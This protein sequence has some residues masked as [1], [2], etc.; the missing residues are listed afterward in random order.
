VLVG[1]WAAG[2]SGRNAIEGVTAVQ[3]YLLTYAFIVLGSFAVVSVVSG[4]GDGATAIEDY[5]GL[6]FR[7][8]FLAVSF[9]LLLAAQAGVPFTTG[10]L[11]KF[12]VI[13][14]ALA[15]TDDT[16]LAVAL[17]LVAML[18]TAV[19]V[20]FYLRLVLKMFEAPE[21]V[22]EEHLSEAGTV[23]VLTRERTALAVPVGTRIALSISLLMTIGAGLW[24]GPLLDF[25]ARTLGR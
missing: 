24:A 1:L 8:P 7:K 4:E 22:D 21:G 17:T 5:R 25:A 16:G 2:S 14:A 20:Y 19:S 6:Y 18:V 23:A 10:F 13:K 15:G 9:T 3:Y 11:A 12:A